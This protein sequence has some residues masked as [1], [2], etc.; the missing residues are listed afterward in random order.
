MDPLIQRAERQNTNI[1]TVY[2]S[3]SGHRGRSLYRV[4]YAQN[5]LGKLSGETGAESYYLDSGVPVSL[6][7]FFDEIGLHLNNQYL[8]TSTS[9]R[10]PKGNYE[11]V[12]VKTELPGVEFFA[13]D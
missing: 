10:G 8:L 2:Y 12:K 11:S 4:Y 9:S 7:P 5:N 3:S 1:W 6:K 13:F